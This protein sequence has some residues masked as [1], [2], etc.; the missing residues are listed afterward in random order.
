MDSRDYNS[1]NCHSTKSSLQ[2]QHSHH[3][4]PNTIHHRNRKKFQPHM[5]TYIQKQDKYNN[6]E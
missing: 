3:Q 2:I 4:N 6:P 5:E 1:E